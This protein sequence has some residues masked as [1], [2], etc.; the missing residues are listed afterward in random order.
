MKVLKISVNSAKQVWAHNNT[1]DKYLCLISYL[2][3]L[4]LP[5][6]EVAEFRNASIF[7]FFDLQPWAFFFRI[8]REAEQNRK[9][10]LA[11]E[12]FRDF[13]YYSER[14]GWK[15]KNT[16]LLLVSVHLQRKLILQVFRISRLRR[17]GVC[18]IK[19]LYCSHKY[20]VYLREECFY[21]RSQ[22]ILKK[23]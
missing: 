13:T 21:N 1:Q 3:F 2:D 10:V 22:L 4:C 16:I 12:L 15:E 20:C 9:D 14:R 17:Q 18:T 11:I 23:N 7:F 19:S 8:L 5:W 6:K